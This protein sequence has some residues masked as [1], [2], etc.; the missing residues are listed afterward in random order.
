[1]RQ[2]YESGENYLETILVLQRRNGYTRSVDV[3]NELNFSRPS[4]SR[5]MGILRQEGLIVVNSDGNIELTDAGMERA[6]EVYE[7]HMLIAEFLQKS[8]GTD[9]SV[10]LEDSCRMEHIISKES[11]SK[12][13]EWLAANKTD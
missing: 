6:E 10:S 11:F 8:I 3:A 4:V 13:K 5:A 12:M 7:R 9:K 2:L 1:M